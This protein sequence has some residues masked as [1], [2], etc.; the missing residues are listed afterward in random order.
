MPSIYGANF[1]LEISSI[2]DEFPV[3]Y[4]GAILTEYRSNFG[5]KRSEFQNVNE[6]F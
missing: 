2:L 4:Y 6:R 1:S 3:D 5:M